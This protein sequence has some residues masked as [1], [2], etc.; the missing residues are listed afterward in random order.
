MSCWFCGHELIWCN[1]FSY[2]DYGLE[3][4]GIVI[5]LTCPNCGATWEGYLR[6]ENK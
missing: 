4:D 3:E 2:E 5:I 6:E 1:D